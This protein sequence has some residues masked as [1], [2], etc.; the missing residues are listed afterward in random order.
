MTVIHAASGVADLGGADGW[1]TAP[2]LDPNEPVFKEEWEGRA[3]AMSLLSMRLSGA[4]LDAF[5]HA[6][7]RLDS[8]RYFDDG[9]Y[10]RWLYG[11]ENLLMDSDIIAPGTVEA[12]ATN[13][14]GGHAEE[15]AAPEPHKPDYAPTA[16]GSI[17]VIDAP[18]RFRAAAV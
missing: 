10:G 13:M 9:Y 7:N 5:R 14:T 8:E 6:M 4:N 12:R 11:A 16:A 2:V 18:Q 1:G 15:P 17:R 3:F